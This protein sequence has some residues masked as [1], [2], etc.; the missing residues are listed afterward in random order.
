MRTVDLTHTFN[1]TMPVYPGDPVPK[2]EQTAFIGDH[3]YN[4]FHLSTG[5][6]IGTHMDAPLHMVSDG[7]LI[8]EVEAAR[9]FGRGRLIEARGRQ[10]ISGD[11]LSGAELCQGDI[12]IVN[13]GWH[14]RFWNSDY[15]EAFPEVTREFAEQLVDA[16]V[17]ILALDTPSP[18]RP[19]FAIHK[20]LLGA[21]VLIIENVT[22]LRELSNANAFEVVALPAKLACEGAPVRVIAR[23]LP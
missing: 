3:G 20:I 12:V 5:M 2:L 11:L 13:S 17:S 23:I 16:N 4:E 21:G 8:S 10:S 15:Y 1:Q 22:N 7:G 6:H 9:F 18:D 14:E 19:P